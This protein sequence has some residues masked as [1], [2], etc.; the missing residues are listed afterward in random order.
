MKNR[1]KQRANR[2]MK[3]MEERLDKSNHYGNKD[4]KV[5]DYVVHETHGLGIYQGIEKIEVDKVEKDYMKISYRD[6]GN[7]YVLAT[8]LDMIQ[9]YASA[10][11]EKVPKINK[12]GT[13]EWTKTKTKVRTAVDGVAKELVELYAVRQ[14]KQGYQYGPDTVWQKEFEEMFLQCG[15]IQP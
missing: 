1:I 14:Q 8:S 9:K 15:R 13:S 3:E 12:L 2:K 6:G 7:L 4:L 11:A 5:G 10:D